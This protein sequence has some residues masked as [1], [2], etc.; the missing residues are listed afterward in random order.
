MSCCIVNRL[1]YIQ[2]FFHKLGAAEEKLYRVGKCND[3]Q[4]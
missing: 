2:L 3:S 1:C 4:E